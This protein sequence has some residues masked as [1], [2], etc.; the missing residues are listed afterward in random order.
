[1][2]SSVELNP[3][4]KLTENLNIRLS[5]NDLALLAKISRMRG[6]SSSDFIRLAMR[7]E[8]ARLGFLSEE[9]KQALGVTN[10]K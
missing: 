10:E 9:E 6:Q 8:F 1:M 2:K 5:K 4:D 7:R 3:R